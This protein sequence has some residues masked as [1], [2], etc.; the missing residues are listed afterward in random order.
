MY[1]FGDFQP[2]GYACLA[3]ASETAGTMMTSFPC[4][5]FTGVATRVK[6]MQAAATAIAAMLFVR[7]AV[8]RYLTPAHQFTRSR[9]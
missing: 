9:L 1:G 2:P 6:L 5:Q 8:A 7:L 3:S 4:F